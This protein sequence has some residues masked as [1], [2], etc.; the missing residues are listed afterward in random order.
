MRRVCEA[1]LW[2]SRHLRRQAL[3]LLVELLAPCVYRVLTLARFF[4]SRRAPEKAPLTLW[5][6]GGPGCSSVTGLLFEL[7]PCRIANEG[8]NTTINEFSWNSYSNIIFLDQPINV[9][10]SYSDDGSTVNTSPVA[11]EDVYAFLELFLNRYPEY[12]KAPFHIAAESYGGTYA[13]NMASVIHKKNKELALAPVPSVK[14]INLASVILANG[15]QYS[16]DTVFETVLEREELPP[17][18]SNGPFTSVE[19]NVGALV[20]PELRCQL[21]NQRGKKIVATRGDNVDTTF[22]DADKGPWYF[23]R[24]GQ[25]V[26]NVV[27]DPAFVADPQ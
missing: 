16:Y 17:T 25:K 22:S 20:D 11:A 9:G 2:L 8:A 27:C 5:L 23:N 19:I 21:I 14:T 1:T 6:N 13:P 24:P 18:G 3:V 10:Y 15:R 12:S 4:E 26:R 7:G